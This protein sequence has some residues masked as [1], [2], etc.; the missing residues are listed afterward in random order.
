MPKATVNKVFYVQPDRRLCWASDS[1][2]SSALYLQQ[3]IYSS[4]DSLKLIMSVRLLVRHEVG[5]T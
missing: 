3:N 1:L 5:E 2:S 4:E